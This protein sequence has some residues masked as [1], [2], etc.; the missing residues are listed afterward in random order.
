VLRSEDLIRAARHQVGFAEDPP[1]SNSG[2]HVDLYTGGR[3]EPWCG[4]FISWLFRVLG[5]PLPGD[6]APSPKQHNPLASIAHMRRV[7]MEHEWYY[8]EPKPG[9]VVFYRPTHAG[10]VV[11]VSNTHIE[12]VEGNW[13]DRVALRE[14]SRKDPRI[15]GFGRPPYRS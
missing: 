10:I 15:A 9:D 8:R 5:Q 12:T 14:V 7:F 4:H 1:R 2:P 6:I 3:K 11:G 13:S